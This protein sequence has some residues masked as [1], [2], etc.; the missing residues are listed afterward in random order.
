MASSLIPSSCSS[1]PQFKYDVFLSFRGEDTRYNF[2]SHLHKAL[3]D[4]QLE[5]FID[6]KLNRGDE[7]SSSLLEA[8]EKS[9]ISIIIFSRN[10]ASSRWCLEELVKI[11][12]CREQYG[13]IVIPVFYGIDP[14]GVRNQTR[15]F[16][17]AAKHEQKSSHK[18]QIWKDALKKAAN[19]SGWHS[20]TNKPESVL[21]EDIVQNVLKRLNDMY[22]VD[23]S[24]LVGID[25][26]IEEIES[27][28]C[29]GTNDAR[30]VGIWG[31]G[32]IGKTTL[33]EAIF[34]KTSSQFEGFW[35][36][37]NVRERSEQSGGLNHLRQELR[38]AIFGDG[39]MNICT[40]IVGHNFTRNRLNRKKLLLVFDDVSSFGQIEYLIGDLCCL[41]SQSRIIITTR[42]KQVLKNCGVN[43]VY[44]VRELFHDKALKLFCRYAFK[45]NYPM[46]DYVELSNKV[47][48][49]AGGVPLALKVLGS[50]LFGK[51]KVVWK[52]AMDKL[53]KFPHIDI[54][55]VLKISYDGLDDE[56]RKIFLDIACFWKGCNVGLAKSIL[57]A[58]GFHSEIGISI[59][60]DQSLIAINDIN[61][62]IIHDLLHTMGR[63]IVRQEF[64]NNPGKRSRLWDPEDIY[65]VLTKNRGTEIIEG[66]SLDMSKTRDIHLDRNAFTNMLRLRFLN[67]YSGEAENKVHNFQ[68][69][70]S[71]FAELR[72]LRWDGCPIKSPLS[73]FP[74]ENLVKLD[75]RYS[76]VEQLWHGVKHL[77]KLKE[78][79][80]SYSSL[81]SCPDLSGFPNLEKLILFSCL[82]LREISPSIQYLNKL[83]FLNLRA[84]ESLEGV[85]DCRGLISLKKLSLQCCSN[86]EKLPEMPCNIEELLLTGTAIEELPLSTKYLSRLVVLDV[87]YSKRLKSLPSSICEWKS[88]KDLNLRD[89]SKLDELPA[90]IETLES[91]ESLNIYG[92][93]VREL[94]SSITKLKNVNS[95]FFSNFEVHDAVSWSLPRIEGWHNLTSLVLCDSGIIELP[96][97]LGCLSSLMRLHLAG[98]SFESI[99]A[100]IANLSNLLYLY[101]NN[102]KKLKC[103][104]KLQLLGI[105]ACNCTSLEVLSGV[106]FKSLFQPVD[107]YDIFV[108]FGNCFKL[109]RNT[110]EGIIKD[111]LLTTRVL[112]KTRTSVVCYPGYEIPEWFKFRSM[113]SLIN[114][115]LP[116]NSLNHNFLGFV[117]CVVV[118]A[119]CLDH[120]VEDNTWS[121]HW[122]C[123]LRS[124]DGHPCIWDG[125]CDYEFDFIESHH[126]LVATEH[127]ISP[128]VLLDYENE[129][130]FQFYFHDDS[131]KGYTVEKCG[132]H[133]MFAQLFE[134]P[135]VSFRVG[136]VEDFLSLANVH[137][138][139][140]EVD[141]PHPK[142]LK[143]N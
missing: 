9:Q 102:C 36:T 128:D 25:S 15:S 67:F 79:D 64:I 46:M 130:S 27:L 139:C 113:G 137:D 38:L 123:N 110:F 20:T 10:Y 69:V 6:Y 106:S 4:K 18:V 90:D 51:E 68:A 97:N 28:L 56:V 89:C 52:S 92:T 76:K 129:I 47:A 77:F 65:H 35:F 5:I 7:I 31:I 135:N 85:P 132:V 107:D 53:E 122:K 17:D 49:Y 109:D 83:D 54:H 70:E 34:N 94:P 111:V 84:C 19:L 60:I 134:K 104:P 103:L 136:E 55:K 114:V 72:Y 16:A 80:L 82:Y 127:E 116:Q 115:E 8:I 48:R 96:D 119:P 120:Q 124:K 13:Q 141:E 125:I 63:E 73:S 105:D 140:E 26:K 121:L 58:C 131:M 59:L 91:L 45:R 101:I 12:E 142:R 126:V 3:C 44:E 61:M 78:I 40:S 95:L 99:P 71:D 112:L 57:N 39:N 22:S 11:L 33:A 98:N 30:S 1:A 21:I 32:G 37:Y 118:G 14:S 108:D 62:I 88:L 41:S 87:S 43:Q 75:M 93:A 143:F 86:L 24:D 81:T 74:L 42:D 50:H 29:I 117:F 133:L 2:I 138:N 23:T 100:S 66:I